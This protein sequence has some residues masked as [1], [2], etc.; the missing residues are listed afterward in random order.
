MS[1]ISDPNLVFYL[2][3]GYKYNELEFVCSESKKW[4]D[5]PPKLEA[6][7]LS[8]IFLVIFKHFLWDMNNKKWCDGFYI[9][10]RQSL[11]K[12]T[13]SYDEYLKS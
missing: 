2:Y 8:S 13:F 6:C 12:E 1:P 3:Y 9:Q 5:L 4:S 11:A 7:Q 10:F